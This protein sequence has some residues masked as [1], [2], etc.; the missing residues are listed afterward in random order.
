[1]YE[2]ERMSDVCGFGDAVDMHQLWTELVTLAAS[3]D[4]SPYTACCLFPLFEH[5]TNMY[6][7]GL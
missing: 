2:H 4:L 1:M 3:F 5:C 7:F 6:H